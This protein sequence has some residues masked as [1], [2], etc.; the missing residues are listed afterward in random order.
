MA[1]EWIQCGPDGAARTER[2]LLWRRHRVAQ[3]AGRPETQSVAPGARRGHDVRQR[4]QLRRAARRTGRAAA[5]RRAQVRAGA[6]AQRIRGAARPA[7]APADAR[8]PQAG[9][10]HRRQSPAVDDGAY[11]GDFLAA[12]DGLRTLLGCSGRVWPISTERSSLCAAYGDGP[13]RAAK[14]RSTP[15][16]SKRR[17]SA[18]G[19]T[20][21]SASIPPPRWPSAAWTPSSSVP[22]ASTPA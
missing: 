20:R 1:V 8:T 7:V 19:S 18:S 9:G 12:V 14:S 15:V 11:S 4:R 22:A 3:P 16:S 13:K 17:S 5:R 6:R 2:R 21:P 10:P